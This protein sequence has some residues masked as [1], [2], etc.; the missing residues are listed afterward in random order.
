MP[1]GIL[2][3]GLA[4]PVDL[5]KFNAAMKRYADN[6]NQSLP[7]V[8][9]RAARKLEENIR[10]GTPIDTGRARNSWHT[11]R[12]G[13][14]DSYSYSDFNGKS[15]DGSLGVTAGKTTAIV[16]SNV[17][18]MG[19]LEDGHSRQAPAGMVKI[20]VA[21]MRGEVAAMVRADVFRSLRSIG[22]A[23]YVGGE[24]G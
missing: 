3:R 19:A 24:I 15:F 1:V 14:T 10:A 21:K 7:N 16:G 18:Y 23:S 5:G 4:N 13:K 20:N 9:L 2:P 6:V 12:P 17:P 11:V 8:I 22:P